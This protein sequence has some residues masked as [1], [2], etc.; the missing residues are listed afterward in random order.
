[1]TERRILSKEKAAV[2]KGQILYDKYRPKLFKHMVGQAVATKALRS[3]IEQGTS[4]TF[5]LHGPS[6]CGKTTAARIAAKKVGCAEQNI[7]QIPAA[8]YRGIDA[9]RQVMDLTQYTPM[10][11]AKARAIIIDECHGLTKEAWDSLLEATEEPA[12]HIYWFFATTELQKVPLTIKTRCTKIPFKLV[13]SETIRSLVCDVCDQEGYDTPDAIIDIIVREAKGSPRQA[14]SNL[15]STFK[16]TDRKE[17]VALLAAEAEGE[18]VLELCRFIMKPG[19]W[20]KAM[21]IVKKLEDES[22]EG[23]RLA[24]LSYATRVLTGTKGEEAACAVLP[25]L[26]AFSAPYYNAGEKSAPL[27]RSIGQV[28]FAPE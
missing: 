8:K 26:D 25:I 7:V 17:A 22:P 1:M 18:H 11:G 13:D 9:M 10:G 6:G 16:L 2:V 15:A 3:V 12:E 28:M 24:V 4:R 21:A 14:L 27:L 23:I 5:L 20:Q 19:S